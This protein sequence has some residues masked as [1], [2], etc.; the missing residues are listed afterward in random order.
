MKESLM[1]RALRQTAV[2]WGA[3]VNDGYSKYLYDVPIEIKVRWINRKEFKLLEGATSEV[4]TSM[5]RVDRVVEPFGMLYLGKLEDLTETQKAD[6]DLIQ[7]ARMILVYQQ[8][9]DIK[10]QSNYKVAF[11]SWR[12]GRE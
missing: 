5:V 9:P 12:R 4:P 6:P 3:P 7:E 1:I 11:L 8:T 2:Y 10:N